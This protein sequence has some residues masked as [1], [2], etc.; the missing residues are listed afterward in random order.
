MLIV[1]T[2]MRWRWP[3]RRR[4]RGREWEAPGLATEETVW[5]AL[6]LVAAVCYVIDAAADV[7]FLDGAAEI[8]LRAVS[9]AMDVDRRRAVCLFS[10]GGGSEESLSLDLGQLGLV[11]LAAGA[12]FFVRATWWDSDDV[13]TLRA[14]VAA[15]NG[16]RRRR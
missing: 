14:G 10:R 7:D 15:G 16:I 4:R 11:V 2:G 1:L 12:I 9:L 3:R 8:A 6:L 13:A 5:R